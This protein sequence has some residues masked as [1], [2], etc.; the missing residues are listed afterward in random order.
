MTTTTSLILLALFSPGIIAGLR[1]HRSSIAIG[2][3]CL[4]SL[5]GV[6]VG[7]IFWPLAFVSFLAWFGALVWSFT[8]NVKEPRQEEIDLRSPRM[9]RTEAIAGTI[10]FGIVVAIGGA[11]VFAV[12]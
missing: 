6:F 12:S 3:L 2:L 4:L 8:G 11:L 10:V 9:R 1:R 7:L 5:I